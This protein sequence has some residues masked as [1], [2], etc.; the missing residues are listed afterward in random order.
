[1]VLAVHRL[2]TL[3]HADFPVAYRYINA[4]NSGILGI[5]MG[6]LLLVVGVFVDRERNVRKP[7]EKRD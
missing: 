6:I 5:I 3:E 2:A 7:N 1:M 4:R